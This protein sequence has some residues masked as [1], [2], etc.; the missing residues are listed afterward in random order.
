M[1]IV[2]EMHN[3]VANGNYTLNTLKD[4]TP[5]KNK[6]RQGLTDITNMGNIS[7]QQSSVSKNMNLALLAKRSTSRPAAFVH[8]TPKNDAT[9]FATHP[10]L[11][12]AKVVSTLT[13]PFVSAMGV[14]SILPIDDFSTAGIN[15]SGY[16]R[17]EVARDIILDAGL[18]HNSRIRFPLAV[19]EE[20]QD[21]LSSSMKI[22]KVQIEVQNTDNTISSSSPS[23]QEQAA[24]SAS[25][26]EWY[27][28]A[29]PSQ[30]ELEA[31][32]M[33]LAALETD[34]L[35]LETSLSEAL[36]T[37]DKVE[38][39]GSINTKISEVAQK[40]K[41]E[42]DMKENEIQTLKGVMNKNST[43]MVQLRLMVQSM[44]DLNH[45]LSEELAASQGA[46]GDL[47]QDT[48][49]FSSPAANRSCDSLTAKAMQ[50]LERQRE[51]HDTE[52]KNHQSYN[53]ELRHQVAALEERLGLQ[54]HMLLK[55][56]QEIKRL[57]DEKKAVVVTLGSEHEKVVELQTM[58]QSKIEL[59]HFTQVRAEALAEELQYKDD[60]LMTLLQSSIQSSELSQ[61][62]YAMLEEQLAE[63]TSAL[64]TANDMNASYLKKQIEYENKENEIIRLKDSHAQQ[65]VEL[66]QLLHKSHTETAQFA[67]RIAHMQN[68]NVLARSK[69]LEM[70]DSLKKSCDNYAAQIKAYQ[71]QESELVIARKDLL[72][73]KTKINELEGVIRTLKAA[74]VLVPSARTPSFGS[75][76]SP[77]V[78]SGTPG[79]CDVSDIIPAA[80]P[81]HSGMPHSTSPL[82]STISL[83]ETQVMSLEKKCQETAAENAKLLDQYEASQRQLEHIT[84]EL[85]RGRASLEKQLKSRA[86]SESE[87]ANRVC[88]L[89]AQ[90]EQLMN[91]SMKLTGDLSKSKEQEALQEKQLRKLSSELA[92]LRSQ[93]ASD[94]NHKREEQ[95]EQE[96]LARNKVIEDLQAKAANLGAE[97]EKAI[98][99]LDKAKQSKIRRYNK[100]VALQQDYQLVVA[101]AERI[102]SEN[103]DLKQRHKAFVKT[104]EAALVGGE[105][106]LALAKLKDR[107][108]SPPV[109]MAYEASAS[110][111]RLNLSKEYVEYNL[112]DADLMSDIEEAEEETPSR[113]F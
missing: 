56:Q 111:R 68:E 67:G 62:K 30:S 29:N 81:A 44:E 110:P 53:W 97:L 85:H 73:A 96:A 95:L 103:A 100:Y 98:K 90:L 64:N 35:T 36:R 61:G 4:M 31:A 5:A 113:V 40:L 71:S 54:A 25:E 43:E 76:M 38:E 112:Q 22:P 6:S 94:S 21:R 42:V 86:E 49:K 3:G 102:T 32:K 83:L 82:S 2:D 88:E 75:V 8:V 65:V 72:K 51:Q 106:R 33:R 28:I 41:S 15:P 89:N 109:S 77:F 1:N 101:E 57:E 55:G 26:F 70:E 47:N 108:E 93:V 48:S 63:K 10:A 99:L 46:M 39:V 9:P 60:E 107:T 74:H 66:Q 19:T 87:M 13:N 91:Y 37:V 69:I 18:L 50:A 104:V 52:I 45:T 16:R 105:G 59:L 12:K 78:A 92:M 58:L 24:L 34:Y 84:D 79:G 20:M 14:A 80:T 23:K 7:I 11:R 17:C 27:D